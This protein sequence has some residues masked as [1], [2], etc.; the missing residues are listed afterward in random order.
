MEKPGERE[1]P[2]LAAPGALAL[3]PQAAEGFEALR[4]EDLQC[5]ICLDL[6]TDPFVTACGASSCRR[7]RRYCPPACAALSQLVLLPP[8]LHTHTHGAHL[9]SLRRPHLLLPLLG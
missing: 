8:L 7:R 2:Q 1:L 3:A 5:A 6:L 4:K 9:V